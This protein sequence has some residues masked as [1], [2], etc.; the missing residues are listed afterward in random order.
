MVSSVEATLGS[1]ERDKIDFDRWLQRI[2]QH[3]NLAEQNLLTQAYH[4]AQQHH[5]ITTR[6]SGEPILIHICNTVDI[7][8]DLGMDTDT[9]VVAMIYEMLNQEGVSLAQIQQQFGDKIARLVSEVNNMAFLQHNSQHPE[10]HNDHIQAERLRKMLLAV[11][12]DVRV[13]LI[14]L[15]ARLHDMRVL[16]KLPED[17]QKRIAHET[18]LIFAPL[19]NRLGIWHIKWELEDMALRYLQPQVYSRIAKLLDAR[20]I[21]RQR[22]VESLIQQLNHELKTLGIKSQITGRAKHIYSIWRKMQRKKVDFHQIFDA[23]ALRVLVDDI[24]D[25]YRVLGVVH[26]SWRPIQ[27]EFDDYIAVPKANG[28]RSLHTAVMGPKQKIFEVQIR[29]HNMHQH[30]EMG[31]ASHWRY[32]EGVQHDVFFE[33]KL[34]W[35]RQV[36]SNP[37]EDDGLLSELQSDADLIRIYVISPKNQIIE[38]P[39][40]ATPLDFAYQIHTHLGHR[41]RG[42]KVNGQIVHLNKKLKTGDRIEILGGSQQEPKRDWLNPELGYL[43]TSRA[44]AKVRTWFNQQDDKQ[45]IKHGETVLKQELHRLNIKEINLDDMVKTHKKFKDINELLAALGRGDFN[46]A[47]ISELVNEQIFPSKTTQKLPNKSHS[48]SDIQVLGA[49]GLL[50]TIAACCQPVPN[51]PIIGYI[52]Q[53][54][55]IVVHKQTCPHIQKWQKQRKERL[56]EVSWHAQTASIYPVKI[57]IHAHDRQGLLRDVTHLLSSEKINIIAIQTQTDADNI[58]DMILNLEVTGIQQLSRALLKVEQLSNII[59]VVRLN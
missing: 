4:L 48:Q 1:L 19:A 35:L 17:E 36:L 2:C 44:R 33:Q 23:L 12:H 13:V 16:S 38:L 11:V 15:A 30:A 7:L 45:Q 32:K 56:I 46:I 26:N 58:A 18:Q 14:K 3:R 47:Q 51:E 25:C 49:E 55:G 50:T 10:L 42:A 27:G 9:L 6:P 59:E 21:D 43:K 53:T 24:G 28:Y 52:S 37:H 22:Y 39:K 5:N 31:V 57:Q 8:A 54:R 34:A 40:G 20:R 29:T 41:C